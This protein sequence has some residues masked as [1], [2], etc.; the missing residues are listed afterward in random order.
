MST[1][2]FVIL[3]AC[4]VLVGSGCAGS[5]PDTDVGPGASGTVA[6]ATAPDSV[7]GEVPAIGRDSWQRIDRFAPPGFIDTGNEGDWDFVSSN[8]GERFDIDEELIERAEAALPN[9]LA[10]QGEDAAL[11]LFDEY[12]RWYYGT[13]V[14][15][16]QKLL[17]LLSSCDG[18][19]AQLD[20]LPTPD[21]GGSCTVSVVFD[22]ATGQ[23][24][25]IYV[26]GE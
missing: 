3:A 18:D 20:E 6:V 24:D 4:C 1:E 23:F 22:V 9:A 2:R 14:G 15:G 19:P 26:N 17:I 13:F 25:R 21:G 5:D 8:S 10:A 11:G 16:D 12:V 7:A